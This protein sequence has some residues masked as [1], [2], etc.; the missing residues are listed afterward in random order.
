MG[1]SW[2]I[3]ASFARCRAEVKQEAKCGGGGG[4][5]TQS[6]RRTGGRMRLL[7]FDLTFHLCLVHENRS[8]RKEGTLVLWLLAEC[9]PAGSLKCSFFPRYGRAQEWNGKDG[10]STLLSPC[11]P[12][13]PQTNISL[14]SLE[15]FKMTSYFYLP[16]CNNIFNYWLNCKY[17]HES[18]K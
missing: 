12:H 5:E 8:A 10:I 7:M 2:E 16:H 15:E 17:P 4:T 6:P 14:L 18:F 11:R 1:P 9:P 3:Q 13:A